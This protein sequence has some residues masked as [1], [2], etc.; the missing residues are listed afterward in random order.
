MRALDITH[1]DLLTMDT[2]MGLRDETVEIWE[3]ETVQTINLASKMYD[4]RSN[5]KVSTRR[6][7][8]VIDDGFTET[9]VFVTKAR[10]GSEADRVLR[11]VMGAKRK[12]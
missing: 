1:K 2:L 11:E 10:E 3:H 8:L 6:P 9:R 12:K 4:A 5:Y 7:K